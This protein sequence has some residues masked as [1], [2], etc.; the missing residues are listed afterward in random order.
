M[1]W[2]ILYLQNL[3][4]F[5]E[6][7]HLFW[8]VLNGFSFKNQN[9]NAN[10]T[11]IFYRKE[12]R[13]KT[14]LEIQDSWKNVMSTY[15][16]KGLK[17]LQGDFSN[18]LFRVHGPF[19]QVWNNISS[20]QSIEFQQAHFLSFKSLNQGNLKCKKKISLFISIVLYYLLSYCLLCLCRSCKLFPFKQTTFNLSTVGF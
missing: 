11:D 2:R 19:S 14:Q 13:K 17:H 8:S 9:E 18:Q 20:G 4:F 5:H 3:N 15:V 12:I 7:C 10:I 6:I 16:V 1:F